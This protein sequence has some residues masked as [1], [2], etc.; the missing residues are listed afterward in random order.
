MIGR[1]CCCWRCLFGAFF[2]WLGVGHLT[3]AMGFRRKY[4]GFFFFGCRFR[5]YFLEGAPGRGVVFMGF[6][7]GLRCVWTEVRVRLKKGQRER[8]KREN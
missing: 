2:G 8:N 4:F 7:L 6:L 5:R 3:F 1:S